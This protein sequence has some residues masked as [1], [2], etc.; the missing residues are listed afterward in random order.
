[1][2]TIARMAV[3][4]GM[5]ASGFESGIAKA[6][7]QTESLVSKLGKAGATMSAAVTLPLA[8]VATMALKSAGDF[9]SSMNVLQSVSGATAGDMQALT[10]QAL[11]LGAETSFSAGEAAD[12]MLELGGQ[13]GHGHQGHHG[14]DAWRAQPG[15]SGQHGGGAGG[16]DCGKRHQHFRS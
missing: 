3:E 10:E 5:D 4:L 2:G 8:G 9:E 1:V 7:Q 13:S 6:Q 16:R 11:R 12:A 14:R 15:G